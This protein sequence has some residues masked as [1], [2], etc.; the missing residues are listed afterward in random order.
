M[1]LIPLFQSV[2]SP[3]LLPLLGL[4]DGRED[5]VNSGADEV[6]GFHRSG[7]FRQ[8]NDAIRSGFDHVVENVAETLAEVKPKLRGWLHLGIV[9]LTVAAGIVLIAL[10]PTATTRVGSSVFVA[11][12]LILFTCS[13]I[14]HRGNWSPRTW[15]VL[16]RLDHAN[17][18]LLIAG[19]YTPFTL[20]FL[21]GTAQVVLL[22]TVWTG[23]AL[24]VLFRVFWP[25]APRWLHTPIYVALGWAAVFF[26]PQFAEG[27]SRTGV[28]IGIAALVLVAVGGILYT[29]GG[30]VYGFRRPDPWPAWF[31]FHELFH[32]FT[33]L[34]FA[35]HYVGVS[36]ATYSL[37]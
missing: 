3:M 28:G 1:R 24:G 15:S 18:F 32:T 16:R 11:S 7:R 9:P 26:L 17:I 23:A 35:S 13:A 34:A 36:L 25:D 10:S 12:A 37:R 6:S 21:D 14:Y 29:L 30:V 19:S 2:T 31:G 20:I 27:V 4:P 22:A 5:R 33:I 8:M